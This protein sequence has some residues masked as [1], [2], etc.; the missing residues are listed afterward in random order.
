MVS[1]RD[2]KRSRDTEGPLRFRKGWG[3]HDLSFP[4]LVLTVCGI[5]AGG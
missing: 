3:L 2:C 5:E 4:G 1:I